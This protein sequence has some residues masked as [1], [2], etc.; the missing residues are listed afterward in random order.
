MARSKK[1]PRRPSH[2]GTEDRRKFI[3]KVGQAIL[4]TASYSLISLFSFSCSS[5]TSP[6]RNGY[7]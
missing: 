6:T 3:K 7:S 5:S 2:V 1:G 4:V